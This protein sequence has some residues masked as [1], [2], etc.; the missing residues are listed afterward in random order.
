MPRKPERRFE[1]HRLKDGARIDFYRGVNSD[2]LPNKEWAV[3][4]KRTP[5]YMALMQR[6]QNPT[7]TNS[8]GN[9][10]EQL[11]GVAWIAVH[12]AANGTDGRVPVFAKGCIG[13]G[14][15][16]LSRG[17]TCD[18]WQNMILWTRVWRHPSILGLEPER[19]RVQH[20]I[21]YEA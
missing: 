5:Q 3:F 1:E 15:L 2:D 14:F 13:A 18:Y 21:V 7:C 16:D 9:A 17:N 4:T 19:Q 11:A 8:R 20:G 10:M 12:H 6:H